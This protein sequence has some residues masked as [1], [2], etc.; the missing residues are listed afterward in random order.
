MEPISVKRVP[1]ILLR[2]LAGSV[3]D[4]LQHDEMAGP[5]YLHRFPFIRWVFWKR[6]EVVAQ[7]LSAGPGGYQAGLDF[8][9]G[10]GVLLPTLSGMTARLYAT[11]VELRPA[12]RLA[13]ELKISNLTFVD[14][15]EWSAR[16]QPGMLDYIVSTDVLEHVE[17]LPSIVGR[18]AEA[19][20]PGGRLVVSGPTEN[21]LYKA[22][23]VLAGFGG[24]GD[25]HHTDIHK[26][27]SHIDGRGE[28]RT[29]GRRV[30]PIPHLI[31]G[32]Y[33]YSYTRV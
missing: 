19:L 28:F 8:G 17:D 15:D 33:I 25:Y 4:S 14:P 27:H 32:F 29:S 1:P 31:E 9:C 13:S 30:L 10:L 23:R 11:D 24:K 7:L 22:G 12:R 16:I 6:L 20:R 3:T 2:E 26:I 5:S 18:F 21:F